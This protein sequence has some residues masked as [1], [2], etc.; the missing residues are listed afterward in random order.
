VFDGG[1]EVVAVLG[2]RFLNLGGFLGCSFFYRCDGC[3]HYLQEL[4]SVGYTVCVELQVFKYSLL[5]GEFYRS[6]K[7]I[8]R[9]QVAL[10]T[11]DFA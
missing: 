7:Q 4:S 8:V 1:R 6:S 5:L 3:T 10:V 2:V 9:A 11:P